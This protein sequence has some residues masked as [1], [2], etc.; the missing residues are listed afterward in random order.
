M[1]IL[2]KCKIRALYLLI[3]KIKYF[4]EIVLEQ[5]TLIKLMNILIIN[6][7]L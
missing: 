6:F 3:G 1:M 4:N 2:K 5:N 7:I